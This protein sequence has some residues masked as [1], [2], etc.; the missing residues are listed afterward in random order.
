MP[1]LK[2]AA[3]SVR[4]SLALGPFH[5]AW[6]GPQ[7]FLLSLQGERIRDVEYTSEYNSR[8]CAARM[9]RLNVA[10]ALQLVRRVCGLCSIAHELAFCMAADQLCQLEP[11]PRA[12]ALRCAVAEL[13]R[14]ARHTDTA[15]RILL[16]IG[17]QSRASLFSSYADQLRQVLADLTGQPIGPGFIVPGGVSRDIAPQH[18]ALQRLSAMVPALYRQIDRLID[19]QALLA[20]IVEVG[21]LPRT[22]AEQYGLQGPIARASGLRRDTRVD[23]AYGVF[24]DLEVRTITQD[25]GDVYARLM[26]ILLEAYE[27]VKLADQLLRELPE[28]DWHGELPTSL[29][30]GR[31]TAAVEAP[32]GPL[33]Y[34]LESDGIRLVHVQIGPPRQFDRLLARTML[35]GALID[36]VSAIIASVDHC[37]ACA[38][39]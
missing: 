37:T 3:T 33:R 18:A 21:T 39:C 19:H 26:L 36:N 27:S 35:V 38:D 17:M 12:V 15:A 24:R 22:A 31:A 16:A 2:G 29:P 11:A 5:S 23:R 10:E 14:A 9:V 6:V 32:C 7:R 1:G 13:E 4:A 20:R 8:N 30:A 34:T 28:G 25:G